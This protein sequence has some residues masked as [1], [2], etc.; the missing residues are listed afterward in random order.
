LEVSVQ[1][2]MTACRL[3]FDVLLP[4]DLYFMFRGWTYTGSLRKVL[5][6]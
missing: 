6:L 1:E 4:A 3:A 5:P 2:V